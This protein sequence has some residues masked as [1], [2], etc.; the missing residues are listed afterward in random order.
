MSSPATVRHPMIAT[1]GRVQDALAANGVSRLTE[2]ILHA[3][4]HPC[5]TE[6]AS[7]S[8]NCGVYR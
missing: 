4:V 1:T 8:R 5:V 3:C 6:G 2:L 7:S